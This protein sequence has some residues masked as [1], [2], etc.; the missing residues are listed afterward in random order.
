[1]NKW[2]NKYT[3]IKRE[4]NIKVKYYKVKKDW[5]IPEEFNLKDKKNW[6]K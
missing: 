1:M 6:R 4:C 5:I 2:I 3:Y